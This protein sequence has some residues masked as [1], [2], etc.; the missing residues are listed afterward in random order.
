M[1]AVHR[2]VVALA[3]GWCGSAVAA[4]PKANALTEQEFTDGWVSLF[5]GETTFGW[6]VEGD[7]KV[8]GGVLVVGGPKETRLTTTTNFG[9]GTLDIKLAPDDRDPHRYQWA[10]SGSSGN[11]SG[12]VHDLDVP[13]L[14]PSP[15]VLTVPAGRTNRY[16]AV[17]YRPGR[18]VLK[19]L[20]NT[21]DLA[22]WKVFDADPKN[23]KAKYE[24]TPAGELYVTGGPGDLQ[25]DAKYDNFVLQARAKTNRT[26]VNSG[27]FLRCIDGQYQ[28][29]YEVQIQNAIKDDDRTKPLDFGTG[30]IYR[31]VPAR[32]V[33]STDGEWFTLTVVADGPHFATWVNGYQVVDWTD[34]RPRDPNPRK[35]LR[36]D[37][38]H[39]SIQGHGPPTTADVLFQSIKIAELK[40]AK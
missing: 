13:N 22:G 10:G 11:G 18:S 15:V 16:V 28:N 19:P 29:G 40:P 39:I 14:T 23:A 9:P 21:K 2:M 32:K 12:M 1:R 31:R 4:E 24:V 27:L 36:T 38:G 37:A 20:F 33:V 26:G 17:R 5:D 30:A 7:A 3:L 25:T 34:D 35:G 6:K 8:E